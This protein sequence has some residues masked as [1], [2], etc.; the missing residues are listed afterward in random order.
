MRADL[1]VMRIS[2]FKVLTFDVYGT[3]ID[4]ESGMI[5][6]LRPLTEQI[7]GR[8]SR[9]QILEAH[10][11]FESTAQRWTPG[12]KYAEL[13]AGV[14]RRLGE[15]WGIAT[16]WEDCL[17]YGHSVGQW[18]A[19]GDSASSLRYLKE[20]FLLAV[21]TNTDND[22]FAGSNAQL[23]I[24]FDG[25]YTA[26]DIGS[27]KPDERN[28]EYLLETLA[29]RGIQ[30]HE[31]LHVAES[32]F[33]DHAPANRHGL[34]NCWIYRRHDKEGFGATM[35]PGELPKVDMT[36]NSLAEFVAAHR[37]ERT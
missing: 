11:Y 23:D 27:Y 30:R 18:P 37:Q 9:D 16:R 35:N 34:A 33:H 19:F 36:Y 7:P 26:E 17:R 5:A 25:I 13:L 29:K 20:H 32:M 2:D 28:F 24:E 31:I 21:L 4:W 15:Y 12:K 22:S 6:A 1:S 14:Y 8:L 10:A 3:L